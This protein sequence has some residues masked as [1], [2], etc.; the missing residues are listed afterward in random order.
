MQVKDFV[1]FCTLMLF[2]FCA[3]CIVLLE[4][5]VGCVAVFLQLSVFCFSLGIA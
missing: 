3:L 2:M 5:V 4:S 1:L